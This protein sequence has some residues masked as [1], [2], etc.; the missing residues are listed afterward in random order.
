MEFGLNISFRDLVSE[1]VTHALTVACSANLSGR[2]HLGSMERGDLVDV[3]KTATEL[4]KRSFSVVAPLV[5]NS[6]PQH[7]ALVLHLHKGQFRRGLK[8]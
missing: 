6:L 7:F 3:P 1:A 2:A 4:G 8:T 5:W